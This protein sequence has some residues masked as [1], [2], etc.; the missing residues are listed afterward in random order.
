KQKG[1][2][3]KDTDPCIWLACTDLALG[4]GLAC[5]EIVA[6]STGR[7]SGDNPAVMTTLQREKLLPLME[8]ECRLRLGKVKSCGWPGLSPMSTFRPPSCTCGDDS[9]GM[10]ASAPRRG[11]T[12]AP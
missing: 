4:Q 2:F 8:R 11:S 6:C 5:S 7:L 9:A 12:H 1:L 3:P 10:A